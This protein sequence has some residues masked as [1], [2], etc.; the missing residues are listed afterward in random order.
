[1]P[2]CA[3]G[4]TEGA[5][6]GRWTRSDSAVDDTAG[7]GETAVGAVAAGVGLGEDLGRV[8]GVAAGVTLAAAAAVALGAAATAGE[9]LGLVVIV[10]AGVALAA[11]GADTVRRC[12]SG[13]R[14]CRWERWCFLPAS[15][16]SWEARWEVAW[17]PFGFLFARVPPRND[18]RW[19][20]RYRCSVSITRSLMRRGRG[21][22]RTSVITG[23]E[24]SSSSPRTTAAASVFSRRSR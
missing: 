7:V 11:A 6:V 5:R 23:T 9:A 24:I 16:T 19:S 15:Q 18:P 8:L 12:R 2:G 14:R 22:S 3:A 4:E 10:V 20:S 21:M 13:S 17:I 1:M